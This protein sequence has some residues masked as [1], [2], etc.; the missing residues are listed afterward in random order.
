MELMLKGRVVGVGA[1]A[2]TAVN[3]KPY[4]DVGVQCSNGKRA[5][6][7]I[8]TFRF[9]GEK[10]P[11]VVGKDFEGSVHVKAFKGRGGDAL[12]SVAQYGDNLGA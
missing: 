11:Y 5:I 2:F 9:F 1:L 6:P 7:E 10:C 12:I 3:K 4:C 8:I